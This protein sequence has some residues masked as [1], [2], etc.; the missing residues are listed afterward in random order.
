M[1][2]CRKAAF[3]NLF[4]H[5]RTFCPGGELSVQ[6]WNKIIFMF[7]WGGNEVDIRKSCCFLAK[8]SIWYNC[9]TL[10]TGALK[11]KRNSQSSR[12]QTT[13][14]KWHVFFHPREISLQQCTVIC[15]CC[16]CCL[17]VLCPWC[18]LGHCKHYLGRLLQRL[19]V[20]FFAVVS[21]QAELIFFQLHIFFFLNY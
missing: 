3:E 10:R 21:L 2:L 19:V 12:D 14:I 8:Q 7:P 6:A 1:G 20:F 4:A 15:C 5:K 13:A 11:R 18:L 16:C 17:A 9:Q